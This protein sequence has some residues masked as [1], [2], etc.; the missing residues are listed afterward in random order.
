[1]K[2]LR[3][4]FVLLIT[5]AASCAPED[6]YQEPQAGND[7]GPRIALTCTYTLS[8]EADPIFE[9]TMKPPMH[10]HDVFG[11]STFNNSLTGAS[12]QS[13][14]TS[15]KQDG[16]HSAWWRPAVYWGG[17]PLRAPAKL[18]VYGE[19]TPGISAEQIRPWPVGFEDVSR[20]PT[21]RCGDGDWSKTAPTRCGADTLEIRME[22]EQCVNP[23][24]KTIEANTVLPRN[25]K[26]AA[27][28]TLLTPKLQ[29]TGTYRLPGA[30]GP[31]KVEGNTGISDASSMHEDFMNGWNQE[32]LKDR[33]ALCLRATGEREPRPEVCRTSD[34]R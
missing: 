23:N 26:C 19:V 20:R 17:Q 12:L 33:V 10:K 5:L 14:P 29:T 7:T 13:A 28:H 2:L 15:C 24:D 21:F 1:M 34:N 32:T 4:F 22:Y 30:A 3:P 25:G 18:V 16:D 8:S 9:P 6:E 27:P 31:L 11:P